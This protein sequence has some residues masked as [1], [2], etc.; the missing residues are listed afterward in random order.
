[1]AIQTPA[2]QKLAT[3]SEV[4]ERGRGEGCRDGKNSFSFYIRLFGSKS[5]MLQSQCYYP[6]CGFPLAV[7]FQAAHATLFEC[8]CVFCVL[9]FV[10]QLH[11]RDCAFKASDLTFLCGQTQTI[12]VQFAFLHAACFCIKLMGWLQNACL[13]ILG[14]LSNIVTAVSFKASTVATVF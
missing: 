4:Q 8:V 3:E 10:G 9:L 12:A 1:M 5:E 6:A 11:Q 13:F 7:V 2:L 14:N